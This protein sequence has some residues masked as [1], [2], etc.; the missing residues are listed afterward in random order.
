MKPV[1][2]S[3]EEYYEGKL[4]N[5]EFNNP[6]YLILELQNKT[7]NR[8]VHFTFST[9]NGKKRS[10]NLGTFSVIYGASGR[11]GCGKVI[12]VPVEEEF[13]SLRPES[14][15]P[16][17]L[18]GKANNLHFKRLG[19]TAISY[20]IQKNKSLLSP[21]GKAEELREKS[22]PA[23]VFKV[24]FGS[25]G[26]T[27]FNNQRIKTGILQID[28]AGLVR[29]KNRVRG[30]EGTGWATKNGNNLFIEI[31]NSN[32]AVQR[33]AIFIVQTGINT[34]LEKENSIYCGIC[35]GTTWVDELPAGSRIVL[36]SCPNKS[37]DALKPESITINSPAYKKLPLGLQKLLTGKTGNVFGFFSQLGAI[38]NVDSLE[39]FSN[40]SMSYAELFRKSACFDLIQGNEASCINNLREAADHGF[41]EFDQ[42]TDFMKEQSVKSD[43]V[44]T[45]L[46]RLKALY[47]T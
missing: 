41:I 23:G 17:E 9:K 32:P 38:Y 20:L 39:T 46:K 31:V 40:N 30:F 2:H 19:A 28:S 26:N 25:V 11:I 43:Q 37:F 47:V 27:G 34:A 18:M 33:M 36:S 3:E 7:K 12:L 13:K 16:D 35:A 42:I 45:E 24:Y 10:L 8:M 4:V 14:L 15:A 22:I 44:D 6:D 5:Q 1:G 29:Y 21:L